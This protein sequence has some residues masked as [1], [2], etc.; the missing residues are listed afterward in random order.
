MALI[1]AE[2]IALVKE[3]ASI[4]DVV[5]EHV[6]LRSAGPGSL[7]GLCPFHDEKT[8]S[9]TVRPG[10]GAYHCFGCGVG[11]DVIRFVQEVDHLTFVEAVERLAGQVG[12]QLRHEDGEAPQ[13]EPA[14]RRQR[15]VEANRVAAELYAEAL[16]SLPEARPARDFLRAKGFGG[17]DCGIFGVGYAPRAGRR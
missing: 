12:V 13:R 3:R 16:L 17:K 11:G 7:K 9:F 5:R 6:S 4:E 2:D 8:P 1:K 15:L 14:G 10:V